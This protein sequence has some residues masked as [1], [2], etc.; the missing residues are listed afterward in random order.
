MICAQVTGND[1]AIGIGAASG[2]FELNVFKP[3]LIYNFLQSCRLLADGCNSFDMHCVRGIQANDARIA[4]LLQRSLMLVTA[5]TPHIGYDRAAQ[6][7]KKAHAENLTLREA[8]LALGYA[9][10]AEL[11]LWLNPQMMVRTW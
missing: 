10:S 11:D 8:A 3:L 4:D 7:A 9:N 5:L 1:V 6:L 2:N